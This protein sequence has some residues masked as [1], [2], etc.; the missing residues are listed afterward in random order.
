MIFARRQAENLIHEG[1][2]VSLFHLRSRTSPFELVREWSRFRRHMRQTRPDVV[3]AQF[4]TATAMFAAL[5]APCTPLVITYRGSDLNLLPGR[6]LLM[7]RCRAALARMLSQLAALRAARIVCVSPQLTRRLWWQRADNMVLPSGVDPN[8][9][10]PQRQ[11]AARTA[12]GWGR[13]ERVVLFNA[14]HNPQIKRLDLAQ[15]AAE[16]ARRSVPGF[17]LEILDGTIPPEQVPLLMNA[18]DCLLLTSDSEGSPTVVQEA[19]ACN[20]PI[21]SV[22]VGDVVERLRG[23]SRTQIVAR[24][25]EKIAAALAE[26]L[27]VPGRS[28]GRR[29]V[30]EFSARRIAGELLRIYEELRRVRQEGKF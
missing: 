28:D 30:G 19:M 8:L 12:L 27:L 10:A 9:F 20:L 6:A 11:S 13:D 23:V 24:Q 18:A 26:M 22:D 5:A 14:G 25:P 21:V 17:R 16:V 1:V 2:E 15:A 29:K 7:T 4:G 3:H